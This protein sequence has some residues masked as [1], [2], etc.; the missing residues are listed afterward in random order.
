MMINRVITNP[1]EVIFLHLA[2]SQTEHV[3]RI[4]EKSVIFS[5]EYKLKNVPK[6]SW[7]VEITRINVGQMLRQ[8]H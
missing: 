5:S 4:D 1:F 7:N 2:E 3:S 8:N 6:T